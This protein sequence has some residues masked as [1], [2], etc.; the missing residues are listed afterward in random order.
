MKIS[1]VSTCS[2]SSI[3][4]FWERPQPLVHCPESRRATFSESCR[5]APVSVFP[6]SGGFIF[7]FSAPFLPT[8]LYGRTCPPEVGFWMGNQS[9]NQKVNQSFYQSIIQSIHQTIN[10]SDNQTKCSRHYLE[11]FYMYFKHVLDMY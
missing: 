3:M 11:T 8:W 6:F 10:Q 1:R 7:V 4:S 5:S 2:Q 9:I